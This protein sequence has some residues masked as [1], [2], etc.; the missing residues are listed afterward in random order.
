MYK[1]KIFSFHLQR[2][3]VL[4]IAGAIVLFL[5]CTD[6]SEKSDG[7]TAFTEKLTCEGCHTDQ[8]VLQKLAPGIDEPPPSSG[9]G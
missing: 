3:F 6:K 4:I 5:S 2:A 9:G 1:V 7:S 8:E